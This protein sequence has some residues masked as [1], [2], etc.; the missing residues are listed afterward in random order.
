MEYH[1]ESELRS[2][3]NLRR[4]KRIRNRSTTAKVSYD[5]LDYFENEFEFDVE[6]PT[7]NPCSVKFI[8]DTRKI[9]KS[10][11]HI[12]TPK[13]QGR[14]SLKP[15]TKSSQKIKLRTKATSS[16]PQLQSRISELFHKQTVNRLY[17][18]ETI[19][20]LSPNNSLLIHEDSELTI[21]SPYQ[22]A[23][24]GT[25]A[26]TPTTIT[27]EQSIVPNNKCEFDEA[28]RTIEQEASLIETH[29]IGTY[30]YEQQLV[31]QSVESP[32]CK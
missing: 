9:Y 11:E 26:L 2:G 21:R 13:G 12:A 14:H 28:Q 19:D 10:K 23:D 6:E 8:K 31:D 7:D 22:D 5:C 27:V 30:Q 1:S 32:K 4:S 20:D 29:A 25:S 17:R 15:F 18:T 16:Q 3:I 24:N